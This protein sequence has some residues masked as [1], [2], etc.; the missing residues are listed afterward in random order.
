MALRNIITVGDPILRK[1]SRKV[2]KFDD[3]RPVEKCVLVYTA[4]DRVKVVTEKNFN[5][6]D[7][8]ITERS[9]LSDILKLQL[10][11]QTDDVIR[12]KS[13]T[14][15]REVLEHIS[16]LF[17]HLTLL[18]QC[19]GFIRH[20]NERFSS[21][22]WKDASR[23]RQLLNKGLEEMNN[24]PTTD[25]LHPIV[26]AIIDLMPDDESGNAKGLLGVG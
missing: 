2:E 9:S 8:N 16:D 25:K 22:R 21:V 15:G 10:R 24:Q 5:M 3:V 7:K 18:Y 26:C 1:V 11:T 4:D 12:S 23:A 14:L 19:M 17:V 6:S 20:Y 13:V